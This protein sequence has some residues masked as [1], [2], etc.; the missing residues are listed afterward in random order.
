MLTDNCSHES[1]SDEKRSVIHQIFIPVPIPR[2][3]WETASAEMHSLLPAVELMT[4][5]ILNS[6]VF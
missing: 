2:V 5:T 1:G 4:A 6:S 3:Q